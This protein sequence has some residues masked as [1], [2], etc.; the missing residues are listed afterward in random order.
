[1]SPLD[2][3][4]SIRVWL[5]ALLGSAH[6]VLAALAAVAL[7]MAVALGDRYPI[8]AYGCFTI[9]ALT[10]LVVILRYARHG[11]EHER[12]Q[13]VLNVTNNTLHVTNVDAEVVKAIAQLAVR[14]RQRLPAPSGIIVGSA[15][16]KD[17][18]RL[19]SDDEA[20]GIQDQDERE[21]AR[22]LPP[23]GT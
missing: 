6:A 13:P 22:A 17:A 1:V 23:E 5:R 20:R 16:E 8:I 4:Q 10:V 9:F 12:G 14:H 21:I 19:L 7:L 15:A 18:I 2:S 3:G 11:P